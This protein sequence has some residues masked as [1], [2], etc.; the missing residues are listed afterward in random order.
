MLKKFFS[1]I[2]LGEVVIFCPAEHRFA[3]ESLIPRNTHGFS[4][5]FAT[6]VDSI[7]GSLAVARRPLLLEPERKAYVCLPLSDNNID[8]DPLF[9][10]MNKCVDSNA[11]DIDII[12]LRS[13][14]GNLAPRADVE[15]DEE[16]N[17]YFDNLDGSADF[18]SSFDFDGFSDS[19]KS[20]KRSCNSRGNRMRSLI[21]L[22][23]A[24]PASVGAVP[25]RRVDVDEDEINEALEFDQKQWLDRLSALV[26]E[27]VA[28]NKSL[29]P[30][31]LINS[32]ISGKLQIN[33]D[34]ELSPLV[35]N[36]DMHIILPAYNELEIRMTPLARTVYILFLCHPEGIVLKNIGDYRDE[37]R[38]IYLLVK[39]GADSMLADDYINELCFPGSDSLQQK[40][41][42][43]KRSINRYIMPEKLAQSYHIIGA[44]GKAY[45]INIPTEKITLPRALRRN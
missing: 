38:D 13:P 28:A 6:S 12:E 17:A 11:R 44:R 32:V 37:L 42:L 10:R 31:E 27:Y 23:K 4:I 15:F 9:E 41:S 43:I 45:T 19:V 3:F 29:P 2:Q 5:R 34:N 26:L 22:E 30:D 25:V 35:V 18:E 16:P 8:L 20:L 21:S 24:A 1:D 40:L 39:P 33:R 14:F 36:A 7:L